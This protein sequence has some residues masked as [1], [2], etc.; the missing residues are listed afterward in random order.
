MKFKPSKVV[1]VGLNYHD[2]TSEMKMKMPSH[3]IIFL[4]APTSVISNNENIIYPDA[5][6]EL[7][8]E[9]ELAIVIKDET[10]KISES[11]SH[12]HILGY[13]CGNDVTARDLQGIDG[14]WARAKS[15]NTFC[16]LGPSLVSDIDPSD[17]SIR[18][19][20]NGELKQDSRTSQMI[21]KP[22]YIVSFIS[23]VMT[24]L[25]GDIILTGTPSGVG[26]M[27]KGDTVVVEIEKIGRLQNRVV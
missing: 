23:Q 3:P 9:A 24:L 18:L 21:F 7:H 8:Y 4:K 19:Y 20:L 2:H 25:P 15:F 26:P 1:C 13:T 11:E 10:Y 17:L 12:K 16:P 6:K 14:Q 22:F 27:Q 5:T